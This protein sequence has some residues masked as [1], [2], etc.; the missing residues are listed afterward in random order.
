[1]W[2]ILLVLMVINTIMRMDTGSDLDTQQQLAQKTGS[3]IKRRSVSVVKREA[4]G[5]CLFGKGYIK[6][7]KKAIRMN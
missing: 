6:Y 3:P 5:Q 4:V 2:K 7:T 1:M